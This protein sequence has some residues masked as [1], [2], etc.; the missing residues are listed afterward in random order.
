MYLHSKRQGSADYTELSSH[1]QI[2]GENT[3][4]SEYPTEEALS[5]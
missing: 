5:S 2:S 1:G 4:T 3:R